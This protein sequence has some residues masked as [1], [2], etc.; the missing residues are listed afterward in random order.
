MPERLKRKSKSKRISY[1]PLILMML[2]GLIYLLA[3]NY[4]PMFG[5]TIAFKDLD[6]ARGILQSDWCGF[7]N[8]EYLFKTKD[9]FIMIRNTLCYNLVFIFAGLVLQL[10]IA[11]MMTEIGK[12][13]IAKFIQPAICFPNMVSII[14]VAYLVFAFLG[15]N[16]FVN[17]SILGG[18]GI[19][20]YKEAKYWPFI[21]TIVNFRKTAGYG[22]IIYIASMSG[23]DKSLYEAAKID[24]A[25]KMKQIFGIT[26]PIIR[27]M[28][29]LMLLLS[30][31]R[32]FNSDFG[33][34]L[35]VPMNSG[36]LY[37]TTQTIDTYVYRA[38]MELNDVSMSSAASVFQ[39]VIGFVLVLIANGV[40]RR[41]DR[42]SALF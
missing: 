33:L 13:K 14:I 41:V 38:L 42:E 15:S 27:P 40:V 10:A 5:I 32:I 12:L 3:N 16:G 37:S 18:D 8:F 34:F 19:N 9:A 35:Q 11:I 29:I 31:G 26:L 6:F 17:N 21:L 22:S 25:G 36:M 39:A 1:V 20:W 4:L 23:I 24:G 2:P 30:V 28:I 7:Q